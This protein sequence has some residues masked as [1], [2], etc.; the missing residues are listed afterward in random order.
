MMDKLI[1]GIVCLLLAAGMGSAYAQE[2]TVF[3]DGVEVVVPENR[4]L[5]TVPSHW[6]DEEIFRPSTRAEGVELL[7][8]TD[9]PDPDELTLGGYSS[10][11][12]AE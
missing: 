4:R 9:C 12:C 3:V 2:V 5:V 6:L 1:L 7:L 8:P 11:D 10:E